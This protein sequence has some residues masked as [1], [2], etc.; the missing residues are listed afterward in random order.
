MTDVSVKL[1]AEAIKMIARAITLS[2]LIRAGYW[3]PGKRE[4]LLHLHEDPYN[5]VRA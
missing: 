1:L 5:G 4:A 3:C 2:A